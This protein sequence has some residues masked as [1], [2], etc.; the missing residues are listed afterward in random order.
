MSQLLH[1][2]YCD[3]LK[4]LREKKKAA[5]VDTPQLIHRIT[6]DFP[7][8]DRP[9]VFNL[10]PFSRENPSQA[11]STE[12][13]KLFPIWVGKMIGKHRRIEIRAESNQDVANSSIQRVLQGF[14]ITTE[15]TLFSRPAPSGFIRVFV[16]TI[17]DGAKTYI[18]ADLAAL[19]EILSHIT[20][21]L[22]KV[23][24]SRGP[25]ST[26]IATRPSQW[27][28]AWIIHGKKDRGTGVETFEQVRITKDH[29]IFDPEGPFLQ[30]SWISLNLDLPIRCLQLK[31]EDGAPGNLFAGYIMETPF[32]LDTGTWP[33]QKRQL[34]SSLT[35]KTVLVA[36]E[37]EKDFTPQHMSA[38]FEFCK[39][40]HSNAR[41]PPSLGRDL[42]TDI[43]TYINKHLKPEVF[44]R[45]FE[46]MKRKNGVF[47]EAW[48]AA[49]SPFRRS[50]IVTLRIK[51]AGALERFVDV[52]SP[53]FFP[54][55]CNSPQA[56][57]TTPP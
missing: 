31:E 43:E 49:A 28:T 47:D 37:D 27:T 51:R 2:R 10:V 11:W 57:G 8:D 53:S 26:F 5:P 22:T 16:Y 33:R 23:N 18:D 7:V 29:P 52:G 45:F 24:I 15:T 39:E 17:V 20:N 34:W 21:H 12:Q 1:G 44:E 6:I 38:F 40:V 35:L 32:G 48:R 25:R 30:T 42:S 13:H 41:L 55:A 4:E 3:T 14:G 50:R 54:S 9:P 19:R 36:R 46:G 56:S